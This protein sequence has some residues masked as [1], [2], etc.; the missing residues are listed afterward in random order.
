MC[1]A[2]L[3]ALYTGELNNNPRREVC[4]Y[5]LILQKRH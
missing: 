3:H 4:Y 5:Y 1:Q 2:W